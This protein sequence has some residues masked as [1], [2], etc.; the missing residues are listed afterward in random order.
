MSPMYYG[1]LICEEFIDYI[2]IIAPTLTNVKHKKL[3][4]NDMVTDECIDMQI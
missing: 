2:Q 1:N 3:S 4:L